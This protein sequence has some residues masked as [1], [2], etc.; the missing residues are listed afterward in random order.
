MGDVVRMLAGGPSW[1]YVVGFGL[2]CIGA[3]VALSYSRYVSVLKWLSLALFAYF[4]TVVTVS[5]ELK[6]PRFGG[7]FACLGNYGSVVSVS[8]AASYAIGDR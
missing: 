5:M 6:L 1:L 2:L 8:L 4:G 3:Q 7:V